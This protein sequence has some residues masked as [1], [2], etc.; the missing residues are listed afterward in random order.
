[1]HVPGLKVVAPSNA[2]DAKGCMIAAIRDG[3]RVIWVEH[4][5]PLSEIREGMERALHPDE[6]SLKIVI[7]PQSRDEDRCSR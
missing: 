5:L 2:H 7:H 1:M 3:S 6:V 4:R